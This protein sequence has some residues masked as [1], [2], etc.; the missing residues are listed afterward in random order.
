MTSVTPGHN[1]PIHTR[2]D[3]DSGP[4]LDRPSSTAGEV[5][6]HCG[7]L[8]TSRMTPS[9]RRVAG[10]RSLEASGLGRV[11][12]IMQRV[13]V[14]VRPHE[15]LDLT[16][17]LTGSRR[18]QSRA[19]VASTFTI[20]VANAQAELVAG[21]TITTV[22]PK[23]AASVG[24]DLGVTQFTADDPPCRAT[25]RRR[26]AVFRAATGGDGQRL[27]K[28]SIVDTD[29]ESSHRALQESDWAEPAVRPSKGAISDQTR[30][31]KG[32]WATYVALHGLGASSTL[33]GR[34]YTAGKPS[35]L[36]LE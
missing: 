8:A 1:A 17:H 33:Y 16:S 15:R 22:D 18:G 30:P 19:A 4:V 14:R 3:S 36:H 6:G 10:G 11:S 13:Y 31:S 2:S 24:S 34:L 5:A 26:Q 32:A 28:F 12:G 23:A 29:P 27:P 21:T 25:S 9:A 20:W 7:L 35:D